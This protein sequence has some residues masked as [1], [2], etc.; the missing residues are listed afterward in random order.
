MADRRGILSYGAYLPYHQIA[1]ETIAEALGQ[2]PG[3]GGRSVA[4]YDED[5]TSMG[6][7]AAR[8][9]MGS[10]PGLQLDGIFF[11]TASPAYLDKTNA[12]AVHAALG[13]PGSVAAYDTGGAVRSGL[14]ALLVALRGGR[15]WL[16]VASDIRTGRPGGTDEMAG[17]DAAAA[18]VVGGD[19]D[20]PL[21]A[22]LVGTGSATDEFLDRWR[23]PTEPASHVWEERFAEQI[24]TSLGEHALTDALKAAGTTMEQID[25]IAVCGVHSRAVRILAA[26]SGR[27]DAVVADLTD[28]VGNP[29]TAQ[30]GL[31]LASVL[32]TAEPDQLVCLVNLADGADVLLLRTTEHLAEFTP[33]AHV[34][35]L[36]ESAHGRPS[37]AQLLSWRG[38]MDREPPRRP[39]PMPPASPPSHRQSHWKFAFEGTRDTSSGAVHLP[40]QRVSYRGHSVDE[41]EPVRMADVLARVATYS[42]DRLAYSPSP[43]LI[44]A[45]IDFDGGGRFRCEITDAE[46]DSVAVGT[47]VEMTFRRIFTSES[48]HNYFWKAR[49]LRIN[50]EGS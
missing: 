4:S 26:A 47:R 31:V 22:E 21:L 36:I 25:K 3:A 40:P 32:D 49:P 46:P 34:A 30:A 41:M 38:F 7:E 37:Y 45:V 44:M 20:G 42:V 17:G 10:A 11:S 48:I 6:V 50:K 19:E 29:G 9:A 18:F 33:R 28:V 13:L 43:P 2:P 1:R 5:T 27:P 24:Y 12:T 16:A 35:S 8:L 14:G 39:D 23:L 15:P